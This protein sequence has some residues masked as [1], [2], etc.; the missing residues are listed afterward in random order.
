MDHDEDD[1]E[2]INVEFD[3]Q[4]LHEDHFLSL[5]NL[6]KKST[7]GCLMF[8]NLYGCACLKFLWTQWSQFWANV[9][10]VVL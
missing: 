9:M 6:M 1:D 2:L 4:D 7:W 8:P 3:F 10:Y 5:K